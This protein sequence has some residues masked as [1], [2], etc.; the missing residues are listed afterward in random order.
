MCLSFTGFAPEFWVGF[1]WVLDGQ[2]IKLNLQAIVN[3]EPPAGL[4][5][6]TC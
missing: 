3:M 6:A 4:E 5:P 1:G 2:L